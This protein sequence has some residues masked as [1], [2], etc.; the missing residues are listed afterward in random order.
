MTDPALALFNSL[1]A[2]VTDSPEEVARMVRTKFPGFRLVERKTA[3][4]P[5]YVEP[6]ASIDPYRM[7]NAH[8]R[9]LERNTRQ[10]SDALLASLWREHPR[11]L[12]HLGAPH[13]FQQESMK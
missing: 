6:P 9:V 10:G 2:V 1:S 8:Q 13:P 11:I 5:I 3:K 7:D 4:P 12:R